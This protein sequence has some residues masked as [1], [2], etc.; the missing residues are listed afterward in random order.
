M[1]TISDE[2]TP[3]TAEGESEQEIARLRS[4]I[5]RTRADMTRAVGALEARLSPAEVRET[6]SSELQHVEERVRVVV[7]EQLND[8]EEKIRKG[9]SDA[10]VAVKEDLSQAIQGAKKSIRAATLGKVEDLATT[11]GDKMNDTR[12]TLVE[13]IRNNPVP[14]VITGVG[15]AWL[16]MNRSKSA[17]NYR[18]GGSSWD[19]YAASSRGNR[20]PLSNSVRQTAGEWAEQASDAASNA[21]ERISSAAHHLSDAAGDGV[22][23]IGSVVG[24][25]AEGVSEKASAL[26]HHAGDAASHLMD[27][28]G[29]AASSVVTGAKHSA[30]RVEQTLQT[31]LQEN[32]LAVGA[33]ALALGAVVGFSLPR[34][35]REDRLMGEARDRVLQQAGEASHDAAASVANLANQALEGAKKAAQDLGT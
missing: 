15:L 13:T 3:E 8:A 22:H 11:I 24:N 35:E 33:A 17:S 29:Q 19:P 26:A 9:L 34:T 27:Q 7:K 1:T 10:R 23:R 16:L 20:R 14:A 12:E 2:G 31:T 21:G 25:A 6:V 30:Q 28:A 5:E 4:G 18:S 32:P